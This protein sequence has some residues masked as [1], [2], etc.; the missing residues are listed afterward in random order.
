MMLV[1]QAIT[2]FSFSDKICDMLNIIP[3][4]FHIK[5][6]ANEINIL[7]ILVCILLT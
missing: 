4:L 3:Y 7:C 5:L 2:D 1:M 6:T